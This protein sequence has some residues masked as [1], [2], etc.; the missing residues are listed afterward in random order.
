METKTVDLAA[1][2]MLEKAKEMGLVTAFDRAK[3]QEPRCTLGDTV[4]A[5]KIACRVHAG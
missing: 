4:S 3:A 2:Q 5:A 1:Q